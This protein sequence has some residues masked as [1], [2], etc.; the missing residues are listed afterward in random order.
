M[1]VYAPTGLMEKINLWDQMQTVIQQ[2][3]DGCVCLAGDFNSIKEPGERIG[4]GAQS[5]Q[6]IL[7][8]LT[9]LFGIQ[10]YLTSQ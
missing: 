2:N 5:G 10:I 8:S 6:K 7:L 3:D 4:R 1:N 9:G